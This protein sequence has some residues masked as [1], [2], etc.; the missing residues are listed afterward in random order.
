MKKGEIWLINSDPQIGD[1]IKKI[2]PAVIISS[3][4]LGGLALRII[5][6][7]SSSLKRSYSWHVD[8]TPSSQNGLKK[9]SFIDHLQIHSIYW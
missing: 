4:N 5:A 8:L 6:P 7:I 3:N 2:R 9:E 1:E